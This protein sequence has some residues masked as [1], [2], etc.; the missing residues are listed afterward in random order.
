MDILAKRT[1][2]TVHTLSIYYY[3][4]YYHNPTYISTTRK[5]NFPRPLGPSRPLGSTST[6]SNTN[7]TTLM[8]LHTLSQYT[9]VCVNRSAS[10]ESVE[11]LARR[12]QPPPPPPLF[13]SKPKLPPG[14]SL[15]LSLSSARGFH[16]LHSSSSSSFPPSSS[17]PSHVQYFSSSSPSLL[18]LSKHVVIMAVKYSH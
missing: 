10:H 3:M 11:A 13:P 18:S 14:I 7:T 9:C 12:E 17:S 6:T 2:F 5:R 16:F 4:F 15:S 8:L 1:S